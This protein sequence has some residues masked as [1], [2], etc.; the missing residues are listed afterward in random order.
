MADFSPVPGSEQASRRPVV[1][2]SSPFFASFP[3]AMA[4]VVLLT[5]QGCG[6]P[7]HVPVTST[8][9]GLDHPSW[10]CTDDVR[11]IGEQ[12]LIGGPLG[13]VTTR[14]EA[15]SAPTCASCSTSDNAAR[16]AGRSTDRA[17]ERAVCGTR[18]PAAGTRTSW[19]V[20]R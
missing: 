19:A 16:C 12:R 10:A 15:P 3:T 14:G 5:A 2:V 6:L 11:T 20:S 9:A 4:I 17:V 1:V 7:H 13:T 8:Q 18:L